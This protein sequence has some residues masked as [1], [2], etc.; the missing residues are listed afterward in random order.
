MLSDLVRV[1]FPFLSFLL[2]SSTFISSLSFSS[3]VSLLSFFLDDCHLV[4]NID[5]AVE[6]LSVIIFRLGVLYDYFC[7]FLYLWGC[8]FCF[9][10]L[11][12]LEGFVLV[13]EAAFLCDRKGERGRGEKG[14]CVYD[15]YLDVDPAIIVYLLKRKYTLGLAPRRV[16]QIVLW[17]LGQAGWIRSF[18][19][20][21]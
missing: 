13:T 19:M 3:L 18:C 21:I 1:C 16:G 14:V 5:L 10:S 2:L 9:L 15:I 7:I 12:C 20:N 11:S 6:S 4:L 17:R 8:L